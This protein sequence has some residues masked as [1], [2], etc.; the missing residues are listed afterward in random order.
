MTWIDLLEDAMAMLR[1]NPLRTALTASGI[2]AGAASVIVLG[3][4]NGGAGKV[5]EHQI[6]VSGYNVVNV[7]GEVQDPI[8]RRGPVV[9]LTDEDATAL[10][11]RVPGVAAMS[12]EIWSNATAIAGNAS[13]VTQY[14]GVDA[15]YPNLYG[16]KMSEGRFF[17]AEEVHSGAQVAVL[18]ATAAREL[19]GN[20]SPL[21]R[22]LRLGGVPV[23][24][25]GVRA[26]LGFVG[27]GDRDDYI[28]VPVTMARSRLPQGTRASAHQVMTVHLRFN[29]RVTVEAAKA[30]ILSLIRERKHVR[31]G[32]ENPFS[33][34]DSNSYVEELN[35]TRATLSALLVASTAISLLVGGVGIMNIMLVSVTERT[36]EIG[37]RRAIGARRRDI[38]A[39]FLSEAVVLCVVAGAAGLALGV[40]GGFVVARFSDWPLIIAPGT[41]ATAAIVSVGVGVIF[42]YLPAHRAAA[43]DPI[44]ALRRE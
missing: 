33:L 32:E 15:D 30:N 12:R 42:G 28:I 10:S 18:G 6:E 9:V 23:Q 5:I 7:Y 44:D 13:W 2:I 8:E 17:D 24:V 20:Q 37:L 16:T 21:G 27:G 43:L 29:P 39:Q 31:D 11:E 38:L 36:H 25:I 14:W 41:V 4:A 26:K 22:R 40:L 1:L 3:A 19:F 34:A 35:S